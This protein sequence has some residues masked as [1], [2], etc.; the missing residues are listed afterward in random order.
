MTVGKLYAQA[1][2][3]RGQIYCINNGVINISGGINCVCF[4]KVRKEKETE[5]GTIAKL[6]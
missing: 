2:L 6:T 1:R 5:A 3:K 4:D